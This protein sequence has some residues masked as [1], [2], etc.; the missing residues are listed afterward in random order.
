MN[1]FILWLSFGQL[2]VWKDSSVVRGEAHV[3]TQQGNQHTIWTPQSMAEVQSSCDAVR[4]LGEEP[5]GL[6][7]NPVEHDI[8][9][10]TVIQVEL[11]KKVCECGSAKAKLPFHSS[12]CP[13][14]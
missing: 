5:F 12:W 4:S 9:K 2:E 14:K 1:K 3:Y 7:M 11:P 10:S 6:A 13:A 8:L